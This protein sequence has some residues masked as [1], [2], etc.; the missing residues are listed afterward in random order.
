[1]NDE[2]LRTYEGTGLR[3]G[4]S[5]IPWWLILIWVGMAA[6]GVFYIIKFA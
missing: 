2:E 5:K 3:E 6:V 4:E 1:M